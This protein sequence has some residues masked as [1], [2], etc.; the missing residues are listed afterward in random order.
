MHNQLLTIILILLSQCMI[1]SDVWGYDLVKCYKMISD[2]NECLRERWGYDTVT[3]GYKSQQDCCLH[4]Q[5]HCSLNYL[6]PDCPDVNYDNLNKTFDIAKEE[7]PKNGNTFNGNKCKS[8]DPKVDQ[9]FCKNFK[10]CPFVS[11]S[12]YGSIVLHIYPLMS[13]TMTIVGLIIIY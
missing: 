9:L 5:H 2:L 10:L 13:I 7:C 1:G 3:I 8:L 6:K 4:L 11:N 12:S